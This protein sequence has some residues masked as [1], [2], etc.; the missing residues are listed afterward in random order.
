ME[1]DSFIDTRNLAS[2][3][4]NNNAQV[5]IRS[6]LFDSFY[7]LSILNI[8]HNRIETL[9]SRC[10]SNLSNLILLDLRNNELE[11]ITHDAFVGLSQ[12][13][14][15]YLSSNK[16]RQLNEYSFLDLNNLYELELNDNY[17][18]FINSSI[19]EGLS[20]LEYLNLEQNKLNDF[21]LSFLIKNITFL[22]INYSN[23]P[24]V[25]KVNSALEFKIIQ[26]LDL[27]NKR[28]RFNSRIFHSNL[29]SIIFNIP[30][31]NCTITRP[32]NNKKI[33]TLPFFYRI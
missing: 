9:E 22:S 23:Y 20:S 14:Y 16:I 25:N 8:Q 24:I 30:Y 27:S 33:K 19:F 12:L 28:Q 15:L 26:K 17:L 21:N 31:F 18:E 32:I 13:K 7:N 6:G 4:L 11:I 2:L 3:Y 5:K 1:I 10:F 29:Y